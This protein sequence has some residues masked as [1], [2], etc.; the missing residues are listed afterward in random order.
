[1]K[2]NTIRDNSVVVTSELGAAY[3]FCE[4]CAWLQ[5]NLWPCSPK[6]RS[7]RRV[8]ISFTLPEET[9]HSTVYFHLSEL[10]AV[11][12]QL[13]CWLRWWYTVEWA[14]S[15]ESVLRTCRYLY[16]HRQYRHIGTF[17]QYRHIGYRQTFL[18]PI[19]PIFQYRHLETYRQNIGIWRHI[20]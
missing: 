20:G 7:P 19:L 16:R 13:D 14:V 17:F 10:W 2:I 12:I 18:V 5:I 11:F 6:K 4:D 15:S 8:L 3:E 9:A 1:M